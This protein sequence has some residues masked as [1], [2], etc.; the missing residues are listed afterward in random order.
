VKYS[1]SSG[2]EPCTGWSLAFKVINTGAKPLQ[3]YSIVATDQTNDNTETTNSNQFT[4]RVECKYQEERG[5]ID[6]GLTGYIYE[7]DFTYNPKGHYILV[8]VNVCSNNDLEG[9][10]I[11]Q[12]FFLT[13]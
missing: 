10:C 6:P 7:D 4:Q 12:G 9:E 11:S 3:S 1:I 5:S 2:V 8:Y 13:P